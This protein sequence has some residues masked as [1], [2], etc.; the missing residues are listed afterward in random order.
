[1]TK[2]H[3]LFRIKFNTI[4][5]CYMTIHIPFDIIQICFDYDFRNRIKKIINNFLSRQIQHILISSY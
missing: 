3:L 2:F 1:M 5:I 4:N